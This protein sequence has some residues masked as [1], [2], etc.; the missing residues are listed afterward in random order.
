MYLFKICMMNSNYLNLN[1]FSNI[2]FVIFVF[3]YSSKVCGNLKNVI[4]LNGSH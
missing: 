2:C 4:I 1:I 3:K